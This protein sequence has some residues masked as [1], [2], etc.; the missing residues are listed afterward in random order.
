MRAGGHLADADADGTYIL[1]GS[2]GVVF[3]S[4]RDRPRG[5]RPHRGS[6][7]AEPPTPSA[8]LSLLHPAE[9]LFLT[10]GRV[11]GPETRFG[12]ETSEEGW[13]TRRS[14]ESGNVGT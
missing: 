3:S 12:N 4:S 1:K 6:H 2:I 14:T 5:S 9:F 13:E 11:A 8:P 10:Q 7:A